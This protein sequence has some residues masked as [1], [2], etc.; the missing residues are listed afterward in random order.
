[1]SVAKI[2]SRYDDTASSFPRPRSGVSRPTSSISPRT[3]TPLP[4]PPAINPTLLS[5]NPLPSAALAYA[6]AAA[7]M[8]QSNENSVHCIVRQLFYI[9]GKRSFNTCCTERISGRKNYFFCIM[10]FNTIFVHQRG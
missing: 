10:T 6:A 4:Q 7:G 1:V 5:T 3:Q 9:D 2:V 8:R